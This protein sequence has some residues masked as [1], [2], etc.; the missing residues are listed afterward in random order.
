[1]ETLAQLPKFEMQTEADFDQFVASLLANKKTHY[2][3]LD[4]WDLIHWKAHPMEESSP[5]AQFSSF[6]YQIVR[7]GATL[8]EVFKRDPETG[9][10]VCSGHWGKFIELDNYGKPI[11]EWVK[12]EREVNQKDIEFFN[13]IHQLPEW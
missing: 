3:I 11:L 7:D 8:K 2:T 13:S 10:L 12:F 4:N 9:K 6:E 1:M 5:L